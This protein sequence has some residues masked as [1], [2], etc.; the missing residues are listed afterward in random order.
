MIQTMNSKIRRGFSGS[1]GQYDRYSSLHR[2]IADRLFAEVIKRPQPSSLLDVGCG[3]GYLT[4]RLKNHFPQSRIV[5]LDFAKG[6][7]EAA[8]PKHKDIAWVL[9]DGN[10]LPF[11][12]G[13]FDVL[14]SNLAYQWAGDLSRAFNEAGRVLSPDG[15][16][17]C[18]LFGRDTCQELFQ[19]L[20]EARTKALQFTRLPEGHQIREALAI[21]GFK[22]AKVNCEQ[23]TIEFKDMYEL[24][25]WLRSIGAN[26]LPREGF[27]GPEA[28]SRAASIYRANFPY[29]QGVGATFEV[30][31]VYAEK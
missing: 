25:A 3:T 29:L 18:T 7:I 6:M 26:N 30:I 11:H 19:S 9:A 15:V 27:L 1:A 14:V 4:V 20:D 28:I 31:R 10:H 12:D 21:S 16:L 24:I 17:A 22:R 2:E 8:I 23:I 13:S 5:G